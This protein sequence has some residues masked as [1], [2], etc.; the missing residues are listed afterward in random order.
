MP[1]KGTLVL[2]GQSIFLAQSVHNYCAHRLDFYDFKA[3]KANKFADGASTLFPPTSKL[4]LSWKVQCNINQ[5]IWCKTY[6]SEERNLVLVFFSVL[7][8]NHTWHF[9]YSLPLRGR[10]VSDPLADAQGTSPA[11][12]AKHSK[13]SISNFTSLHWNC[14]PVRV[15]FSRRPCHACHHCQ[16]PLCQEVEVHTDGRQ[17]YARARSW[18]RNVIWQWLLFDQCFPFYHENTSCAKSWCYTMCL[19]ELFSTKYCWKEDKLFKPLRQS[20]GSC[21][22]SDISM[23]QTF[24]GFYSAAIG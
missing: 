10:L 23:S 2:M 3:K 20:K 7:A 11:L 8:A 6:F 4:C 15:F 5:R 24:C 16:E 1:F 13:I 21:N 18:S 22:S 17:A 9:W 19:R 14:K 12:L